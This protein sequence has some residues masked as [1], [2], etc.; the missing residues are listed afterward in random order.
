MLGPRQR[1]EDVVTLL[2]S[3][4]RTGLTALESDPQVGGQHES[5]MGVGIDAGP[6]DR[7]AVGAG[8]VLPCR[9]D[10]AV[11]EGGLAGHR[12]LD[13]AAH[14]AHGA[15][16]QVFGIPVHRGASVGS[17]PGL[18]VMPGTHHQ[19]VPHH[20]PAGRRLPGGL[21]D[22]AARQIATGGRNRDAVGPEPEVPGTAVQDRPEHAG[23]IRP[24]H[25][26]PFHRSRGRNQAGVLAVGQERVVG[27]RGERGARGSGR[28]V[29]RRFG[30]RQGRRRR[31]GGLRDVRQC[32]F[33]VRSHSAIMSVGGPSVHR[34]AQN[35]GPGLPPNRPGATAE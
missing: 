2:E 7:L 20:Q 15:Q 35:P 33:G 6:R 30:N 22:Q 14:T 28:R 16:Q 32:G 17:G 34:T 29:G 1:H 23:G 4:A 24:R 3:G 13:G 31:S 8:G 26:H 18:D 11:V 19:R 5:R 9:V 12:Q 10:A 25:A 21:H 27:D